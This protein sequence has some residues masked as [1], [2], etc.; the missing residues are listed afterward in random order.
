MRGRQVVMIGRGRGSRVGWL[1]G[2]AR[3]LAGAAGGCVLGVGGKREERRSRRVTGEEEARAEKPGET[4][5]VTGQA[6]S[7]CLPRSRSQPGIL[8]CFAHQ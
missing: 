6:G 1:A 7:R 5:R 3:S 8:S 4:E 2:L